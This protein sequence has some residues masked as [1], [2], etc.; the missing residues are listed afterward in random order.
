ML[1]KR[2]LP[3][4]LF[5]SL[6]AG[7]ALSPPPAFAIGLGDFEHGRIGIYYRPD[8]VQQVRWVDGLAYGSTGRERFSVGPNGPGTFNP[9]EWVV[10]TDGFGGTETSYIIENQDRAAQ[11]FIEVAPGWLPAG[12][13][14]EHQSWEGD[15]NTVRFE[16]LPADDDGGGIGGY[17]AV[18]QDLYV[19]YNG[20][21]MVELVVPPE[22]E[23][24]MNQ[25][26]AFSVSGSDDYTDPSALE[27]RWDVNGDGNW[28]RD[29]STETTISY[30]Y[31]AAGLTD[32]IL[33][34]RDTGFN[35]PVFDTEYTGGNAVG[36][37]S[38][39]EEHVRGNVRTPEPSTVVMFAV[40]IM[41]M[42]ILYRWQR[43]TSMV[44]AEADR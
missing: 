3:C 16:E 37:Y 30:T 38:I 25:P 44:G 13:A 43:G 14:D 8:T 27:Y 11:I 4:S 2:V 26:V 32:V 21:P 28:D 19:V 40:A 18:M 31:S 17:A 29:W 6:V 15:A 20:A 1:L 10:T 39:A 42:G 22:D 23:W 41:G 7:V 34:A 33:Q 5:I 36:A 35:I 12:V 24:M 9:P